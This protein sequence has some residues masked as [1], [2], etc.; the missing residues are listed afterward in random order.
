VRSRPM[1]SVLPWRRALRLASLDEHPNF[2][3]IVAVLAKVPTLSDDEITGLADRWR[4]DGFVARARDHALSPD[5]P[6]VIEVLA[7]FDQVD[8]VLL[9]EAGDFELNPAT[10]TALK[11]I[12]DVLAAS[13]A[14]PVLA[15]AEYLA[16]IEPWRRVMARKT[17]AAPPRTPAGD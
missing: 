11:A 15:R 7:L 17:P 6:L 4:D 13:Y 9:G 16:L 1:R 14:R 2:D 3:E 8:A 5:S 10:R 12:R